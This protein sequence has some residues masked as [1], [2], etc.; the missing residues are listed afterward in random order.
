LD[1]VVFTK[2]NPGDNFVRLLELCIK[3]CSRLSSV[4]LTTGT[5]SN[6]AAD[7]AK[8]LDTIR[9]SLTK[10][11]QRKYGINLRVEYSESLH[12]REIRLIF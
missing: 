1:R 4:V 2:R 7:Q 12:D 10:I 11:P 6:N 8:R 9:R 3:K 5:D